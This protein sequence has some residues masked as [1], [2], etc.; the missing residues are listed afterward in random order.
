[1]PARSRAVFREWRAMGISYSQRSA[2]VAMPG[3]LKAVFLDNRLKA[4]LQH[5][6]IARFP[7]FVA[8]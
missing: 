1:L 4:E 7:F 6:L 2:R 8:N 3:N 5:G